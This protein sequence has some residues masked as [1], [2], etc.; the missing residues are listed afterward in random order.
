[1]YASAFTKL[2]ALA[3]CKQPQQSDFIR[4]LLQ[5]RMTSLSTYQRD[6]LEHVVFDGFRV[7]QFHL[8]Q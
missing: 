8:A 4:G 6:F 2:S 7:I 5:L 3:S 1:M